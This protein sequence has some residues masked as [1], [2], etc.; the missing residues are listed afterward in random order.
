MQAIQRFT[1]GLAKGHLG[2]TFFHCA[3]EAFAKAIGLR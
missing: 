3:V 1:Q 2:R